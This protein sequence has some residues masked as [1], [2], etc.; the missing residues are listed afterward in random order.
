MRKVII[1]SPF[2]GDVERNKT[3][4]QRCIRD[5]IQRGESPYAS[6]QMLTD[7]LDDLDPE[8]RKAGIEAGFAWAD[9]ADLVVFYTDYDISEGMMKAFERHVEDGR[10]GKVRQRLIGKNE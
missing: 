5:C 10:H 7:A 4:L 3:Y 6:H 1:E 2:A 8:E 9:D